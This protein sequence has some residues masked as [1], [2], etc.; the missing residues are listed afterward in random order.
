MGGFNEVADLPSR[1][2]SAGSVQKSAPRVVCDGA[3]T[4]SSKEEVDDALQYSRKNGALQ[5]IV[6]EE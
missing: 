1:S 5:Y 3:L 4:Y 6:L 2:S